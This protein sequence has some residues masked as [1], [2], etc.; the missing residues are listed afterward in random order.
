MNATCEAEASVLLLQEDADER[1]MFD[2]Q[3]KIYGS[4]L[5]TIAVH[6]ALNAK[7]QPPQGSLAKMY[8]IWANEIHRAA[9]FI[10]PVTAP[11]R[12]EAKV[13]PQA[14]VEAL[15]TVGWTDGD[16]LLAAAYVR[17]RIVRL[18]PTE[19]QEK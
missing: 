17:E 10:E 6:M 12:V 15:N 11:A 18:T 19:P 2:D 14:F 1:R 9:A 5:K 13:T 4:P 8:A 7:L 16:I 3:V